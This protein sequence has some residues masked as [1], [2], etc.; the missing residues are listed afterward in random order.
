MNIIR[1]GTPIPPKIPMITECRGC[2]CVFT[3]TEQESC[4]TASNNGGGTLYYSKCPECGTSCYFD[5]G[6]PDN[7]FPYKMGGYTEIDR[8]DRIER[9]R[10]NDSAVKQAQANLRGLIP[11]PE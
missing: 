8:A 10:F 6:Y 11:K 9:Q 5:T 2:T 1:K 4:G 3:F 7:Y